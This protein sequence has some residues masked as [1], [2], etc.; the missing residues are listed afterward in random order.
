MTP[1]QGLQEIIM[2][3][4]SEAGSHVAVQAHCAFPNALR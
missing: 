3:L 1:E 2:K 4:E